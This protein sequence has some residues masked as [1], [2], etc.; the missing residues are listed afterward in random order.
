MAWFYVNLLGIGNL[1]MI[2]GVLEHLIPWPC[3]I[4]VEFAVFYSQLKH[5]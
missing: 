4:I 3:E 2:M 1:S 5:I